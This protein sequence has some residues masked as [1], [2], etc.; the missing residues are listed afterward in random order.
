MQAIRE[1][2]VTK[3]SQRSS[4]QRAN[5]AESLQTPQNKKTSEGVFYLIEEH[6]FEVLEALTD[7]YERRRVR[8]ESVCIGPLHESVVR[9]S[10][11]ARICVRACV[12]LCVCVCV[13]V[14]VLPGICC[15]HIVCLSCAYR[16]RG[17][18]C[19]QR[20][21]VCVHIVY[22]LLHIILFVS[23]CVGLCTCVYTCT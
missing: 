8:G 13:C 23:V 16:V 12:S 1:K 11:N 17:T 15:V 10:T 5:S 2:G 19:L 4:R 18:V 7:L 6:A 3:G 22:M 20:G 9:G 21:I 14:C